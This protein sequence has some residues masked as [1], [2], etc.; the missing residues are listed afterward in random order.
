MSVSQ[1]HHI[2]TTMELTSAFMNTAYNIAT[3][4]IIKIIQFYKTEPF[5]LFYSKNTVE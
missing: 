3:K 2:L 1:I 5:K 4:E